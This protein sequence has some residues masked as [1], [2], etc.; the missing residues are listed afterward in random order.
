MKITSHTFGT[1][2][3]GKQ[4]TRFDMTNANGMVV[5]ALDYGCTI[6]QI[7]APDRNGDLIDIALGYDSIQGYEEGSCYFVAFV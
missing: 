7:L 4:V 3:S 2:A 6:Q 5:S 1:D